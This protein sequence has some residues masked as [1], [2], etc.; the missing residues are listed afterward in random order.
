LQRT[1]IVGTITPVTQFVFYPPARGLISISISQLRVL[2]RRAGATWEPDHNSA[3]PSG[4]F[5]KDVPYDSETTFVA[6]HLLTP[7]NTEIS[8]PVVKYI[9]DSLISF[10]AKVVYGGAGSP[11]S[12]PPL[13]RPPAPQVLIEAGDNEFTGPLEWIDGPPPP[14]PW[15]GEWSGSRAGEETP[16]SRLF[17]GGGTT[18]SKHIDATTLPAGVVVTQMSARVYGARLL[19]SP[20]S[21]D[22]YGDALFDETEYAVLPWADLRPGFGEPDDI[23]ADGYRTFAMRVGATTRIS[24]AL[25]PPNSAP[26]GET[27]WTTTGGAVTVTPAAMQTAETLHVTAPSADAP[28]YVEMSLGASAGRSNIDVHTTKRFKVLIVPT[29]W[30]DKMGNPSGLAAYWSGNSVKLQEYLD[31]VYANG[32]H[33]EFLVS[34]RGDPLDVNY[35]RTSWPTEL[36]SKWDSI[37]RRFAWAMALE[38]ALDG[39]AGEVIEGVRA[40]AYDFVLLAIPRIKRSAGAVGMAESASGTGRMAVIIP[41]AGMRTPAHEI[42]HLFGNE[43]PGRA[44]H[45]RKKPVRPTRMLMGYRHGTG[46]MRFEWETI[47]ERDPK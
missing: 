31:S 4:N 21:P 46:F 13:T 18:I 12:G 35:P 14:L 41:A 29:Q 11:Y 10:E 8:E 30:V 2:S 24:P 38:H 26:F 22:P 32:P 43:H 33:V 1:R 39:I 25:T 40:D 3:G 7:I 23:L 28:G 15:S 44:F 34:E 5:V 27:P 36:D 17:A 20:V 47:R 42:G 45:L 19:K 9:D 16:F 6:Q 37:A